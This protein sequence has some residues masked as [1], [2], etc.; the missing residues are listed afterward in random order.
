MKRTIGFTLI[1]LL[2]VVSIISLLVGI[3]VPALAKARAQ[4]RRASCASQ[5]HQVGLAMMAYMQDSHD[6]MPEVSFMPSLGPAPLTN[7]KDDKPIYLADVLK[8]HL[9]GGT[10]ALE[11]PDDRPWATQRP[12]PNTGKSFFQS[13]R[14]SYQYRSRL[15]GLTP[16]EFG[17]HS[18]GRWWHPR[19]STVDHITLPAT[20]WFACDY[21]NF[22][23]KAGQIGARRYVYID[24]HVSDFEN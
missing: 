4:S 9:K 8:R 3:L 24:G 11:C 5:L 18:G 19:E 23:G 14:C 21:D 7:T 12:V 2:V 17:Q 22:H 6:R 20:V 15:A 10:N 13:E 16:V 1:E